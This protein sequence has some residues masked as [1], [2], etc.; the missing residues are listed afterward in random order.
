VAA[1]GAVAQK[2]AATEPTIFEEPYR[3]V[4]LE[5]CT[6]TIAQLCLR[7]GAAALDYRP[8]QYVLLEDCHHEV[9]PRSY[10]IANAPRPNGSISLLVT[11]VPRGRTSSWI[12][13]RLRI[14]DD[15][16]LS[17]PYGTFLDEP[18]SSAPA[19]FLAAGSGL[20]PIRSLVEAALEAGDGRSL[21]LIHSARTEADV[22]DRERF[23]NWRRRHP[24]FRF[25]RTLTRAAG[26]PPHG[27]IPPLLPT[28]YDA[29]ADHDVFIAGAAGFVADCAAAAEAL[30]ACPARIHTEAFFAAEPPTT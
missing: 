25:L 16:I 4:D 20:A 19:L 8:G 22:I 30:G 12:H 11:R 5:R 14:G 10:S 26:D 21:T 9:P 17:G 6:A 1:D 2:D 23:D 24:N 18:G 7:P 28:M 29:L 3:L 27:R 15:V 13:S